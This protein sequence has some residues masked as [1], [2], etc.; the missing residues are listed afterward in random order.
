LVGASSDGSRSGGDPHAAAADERARPASSL[1]LPS[2]YV[3]GEGGR[4]RGKRPAGNSLAARR[5]DVE[6]VWRGRPSLNEAEFEECARDLL[7]LPGLLT[8]PVMRRVNLLGGGG[9]ADGAGSSG[10]SRG[11]GVSHDSSS[12]SSSSSD[13]GSKVDGGKGSSDG[14]ELRV[15]VE[16]FLAFW[17]LEVEPYDEE[18]RFFRLVKQPTANAFVRGM[19]CLFGPR[20]FSSLFIADVYAFAGVCE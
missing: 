12:N 16:A 7:G 15:S 11:A 18:E 6:A 13:V 14:G 10:S 8:V 4:G 2:F 19:R 20:T 9:G 1:Q 17:A 5:L 3:A